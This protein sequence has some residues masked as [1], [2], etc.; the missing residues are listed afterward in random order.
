MKKYQSEPKKVVK[1]QE[2]K[3]THKH[4][5]LSKAFAKN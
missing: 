2:D 1:I 4:F 5:S 3:N